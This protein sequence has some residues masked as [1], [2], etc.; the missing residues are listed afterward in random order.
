MTA[1]DQYSISKGAPSR[2]ERAVLF[3]F[4]TNALQLT[5]F[6][7][8]IEFLSI[9][10]SGWCETSTTSWSEHNV[11]FE[12]QGIVQVRFFLFSWLERS[13]TSYSQWCFRSDI[14]IP[15]LLI[16]RSLS[17][18]LAYSI[19]AE[20]SS[21]CQFS[22]GL[23]IISDCGSNKWLLNFVGLL[24]RSVYLST[25]K[26]HVNIDATLRIGMKRLEEK[27]SNKLSFVANALI[28][29]S[30]SDPAIRILSWW[31]CL[32]CSSV[33]AILGPLQFVSIYTPFVHNSK[34]LKHESSVLF[35]HACSG[36]LLLWKMKRLQLSILSFRWVDHRDS[37]FCEEVAHMDIY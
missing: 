18:K 6:S 21:P 4:L 2:T 26:I 3:L 29:V 33:Y 8:L 5:L 24:I 17:S 28:W 13:V 37:G 19:F 20:W 23:S 30:N 12:S 15:H 10:I 31:W 35:S 1:G 22:S 14:Q 25:I 9:A 34:R 36:I 7:W 11:G 32:Y 27:E 16:E